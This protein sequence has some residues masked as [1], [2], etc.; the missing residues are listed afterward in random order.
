MSIT[1]ESCITFAGIDQKVKGNKVFLL[2]NESLLD[3]YQVGEMYVSFMDTTKK[4]G[5]PHHCPH[6]VACLAGVTGN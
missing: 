5:Q 1:G 6:R 4:K 2:I 3:A